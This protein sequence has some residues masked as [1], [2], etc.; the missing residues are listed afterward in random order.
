MKRA[1]LFLA[2]IM[3]LLSCKKNSQSPAYQSQGVI[4]G[5]LILFTC[6]GCAGGGLEITIKNDPSKNPPPYYMI[7]SSLQQLGIDPNTNFPINVSLDWKRDTVQR[8]ASAN[9]IIVSK[10]KVNN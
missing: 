5:D 4:F 3:L 7:N 2:I 8:W 10:I 9:Y 1:T 6:N